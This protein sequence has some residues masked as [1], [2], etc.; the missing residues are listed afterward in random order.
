[1]WW[2]R[3]LGHRQARR[4]QDGP[5]VEFWR[6]QSMFN[7]FRRILDRNN[8]V[9]ERMA[10]MERALGG[11]YIFDRTF[12]ENAV[13]RIAS[14]VH[15]VVYSLNALTGNGHVS[16]YDRYQDI[17]TI[18]DDILS[19]NE[20]ATSAVAV[21]LLGDVGW[22]LEPL[23]GI[24]AVCLAEL[25]RHAPE[26]VAPGF[27]VTRHAV[28]ALTAPPAGP[29][30]P[31]GQG[32]GDERAQLPR[33][34]DA[35]T[36]REQLAEQCADLVG[37][38]AD[39]RLAVTVTRLDEEERALPLAE[40]RLRPAENGGRI[41][42][43]LE[44]ARGGADALFPPPDDGSAA[45]R[46]PAPVT[47]RIVG[48]RPLAPELAARDAADALA[49]AYVRCLEDLLRTLRDG[50]RDEPND[51]RLT[52]L[53]CRCDAA[54]LRGTVLSSTIS[55]D[56]PD[57]GD[58]LAVHA[59]HPGLPDGGDTYLLRRIQPFLPVRTD[60]P[61]RPPGT[62]FPDGRLATDLTDN[63]GL[64]RG[65]ALLGPKDV[66]GLAETS[67]TLERMLGSPV[68]LHWE[69]GRDGGCRVLRVEALAQAARE[70]DAGELA[71]EL[72]RAELLSRGGQMV[73]SGVAAGRV[74]H[75]DEDTPPSTF[76]AGAVAVA[77]SASPRLTPI[78]RRASALLTQY[79]TAAG[80]LATVARELRLP[81]VFGVPDLLRRLPDGTEITVDAAETR[82]YGGVLPT[83]LR[84]GAAGT[85]LYPTDPEYRTLR[86]LLRFIMPLHLVNPE[87]PDFTPEGC[88]SFH[89]V[90]H[91]CHERAVDEL[92]HFQE[93]RPGLGSIRTRRMRLGR[94]MD[95]RALDIGGGL[96]PNAPREPGP[97]DVSSAPFA[98]FLS[99]LLH[100]DAWN[101][102]S[103]SLGLRDIVAGM[104][105]S[106]NMLSAPPETLGENLALINRDYLNLSLRLGF[107]FS[108][109]DAYLGND[110][111]RNYVYFR[112][113]GGLADPERRHRRARFLRD[114]L[115]AMDFKV[116]LNADLVVGRLK[117][118]ET[119]VLRS[120]LHVLGALTAYSRQRDTALGSDAVM[121]ALFDTFNAAFLREFERNAP[122]APEIS[123][124]RPERSAEDSFEE[125]AACVIA[126]HDAADRPA[127]G[128]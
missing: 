21:P 39:A 29:D 116:S 123:G 108:V 53:V 11:E 72:E 91:Y 66:Q 52:A 81:A 41:E 86:R 92:A 7:N 6:L 1:M 112:F 96:H 16:L 71:A 113:A 20:Q 61:R 68:A 8:A 78:L 4:E 57:L 22:E 58:V 12:L 25:R 93:R 5:D 115:E 82:V 125:A 49:A 100:P 28:L 26:R 64:M 69:R 15:H 44:S 63:A 124:S 42:I 50:E 24:D 18:L 84:F 48:T 59:R 88:R 75:V 56:A 36:V 45:S 10:D 2:R 85:D 114:V 47:G 118:T 31:F 27:A 121:R 37:G 117:S 122:T 23:V 106:M 127:G 9:L 3:L 34:P 32:G 62:R 107:H 13:R 120:A 67:T 98:A 33:H 80:H 109:V 105:R 70:I 110:P 14:D 60:I 54:G 126:P 65:S 40:F 46:S 76:P 35:D 95:I 103:A 73:Q 102:E 90:I 77:R 51:A 99:G 111:Q 101:V 79:G 74:V 94:P 89:D 97:Q 119:D 38:D 19:G 55:D 30:A 87:S 43:I 104:P 128:D 83:L 17:R